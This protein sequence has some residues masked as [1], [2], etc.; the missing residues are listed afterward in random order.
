MHVWSLFY[1]IGM[2]YNDFLNFL[3]ADEDSKRV[4]LNNKYGV[5]RGFVKIILRLLHVLRLLR[6]QRIQRLLRIQWILWLLKIQ[7]ILRLLR[8]EKILRML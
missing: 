2:E 8:I 1:L 6:I 7:R 3:L 4:Q 5:R